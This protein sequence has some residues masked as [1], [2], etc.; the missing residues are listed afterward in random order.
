MAGLLDSSF[1]HL[2]TTGL[3][4]NAHHTRIRGAMVAT[5]MTDGFPD[6]RPSS[7]SRKVPCE[8]Q[9]NGG[10]GPPY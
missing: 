9:M 4:F 6:Y 10:R 2:K 8:R 1:Q 5:L 7:A 3:G